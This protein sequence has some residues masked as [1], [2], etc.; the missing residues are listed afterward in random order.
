[1][2]EVDLVV[3]NCEN[4]DHVEHVIANI[5]FGYSRRGDLKLTLVS[6][7]GTPSELLSFR[8]NDH[9]TKGV[10]FFPFMTLFNWGETPRGKWTLRVETLPSD[11]QN[12]VGRL[13]SFSLVLYGS[14]KIADDNQTGDNATKSNEI[15]QKAQQNRRHVSAGAAVEKRAYFP[16]DSDVSRIY[17]YEIK[18]SREVKIVSKRLIDDNPDLREIMKNIEIAEEQT[19][20]SN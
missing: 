12:Y 6:P 15:D 19:D 20:K 2:V 9:N 5:S 10:C 14:L 4:I 13:Q 8:R 11:D 1:M 18:R 17:R 3:K 16:S 7:H